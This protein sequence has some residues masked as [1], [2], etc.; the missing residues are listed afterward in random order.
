MIDGVTGLLVDSPAELTAAV[1][2]LLGDADRRRDL[3]RKARVRAGEFSWAATGEG[4]LDVLTATADG[5]RVSG[6]FPRTA[7]LPT[8]PDREPARSSADR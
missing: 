6:L 3:G 2:E 8:A 5:R 7:G 1:A 4:V